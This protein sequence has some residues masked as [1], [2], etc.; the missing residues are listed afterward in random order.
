MFGF[1]FDIEYTSIIKEVVRATG[2]ETYL[3]LGVSTG[4]NI[5]VITPYCKKCVGVDIIDI[6]IY[7][8]FE[9]HETTTWEFFK[10]NT[11]MFDIIF[12][13]ADHDFKSVKRD[14]ICAIQVLNKYGIIFLH[15]TDPVSE[16]YLKPEL[17]SDS[18]MMINWINRYHDEYLNIVT[19]PVSVAGLTIITRK[20][21]RRIN[22]FK[23]A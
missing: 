10:K 21:D 14:F 2:C 3:E 15:D 11:A 1:N 20:K 19:L 17:C 4:E 9:F 7:N 13:D 12:I 22:E 5:H 6:R 23:T 16:E 8:D 18:Y